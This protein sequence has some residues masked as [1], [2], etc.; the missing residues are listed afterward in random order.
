V[1]ISELDRRFSPRHLASGD[2]PSVAPN[3]DIFFRKFEKDRSFLYRMHPDGSGQQRVMD[4]PVIDL[5]SLSPDGKWLA[6]EV[7]VSGH[8]FGWS[9]IAYP[10]AAGAPV[11]LC[12]HCHLK[13]SP[14]GKSLYFWFHAWGGAEMPNA[15]TYIIPLHAGSPVPVFRSPL[16]SEDQVRALPGV[17]ALVPAGVNPGPGGR[18]AF[19]RESVQRN[20]YR[21]PLP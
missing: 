1:W 14:D 5:E 13:W 12:Y 18:F 7:P 20:L 17:Q 19:S 21:I 15:K 6:V 10:L 8:I 2:Q 4:S 3:G 9:V 11:T 16:E